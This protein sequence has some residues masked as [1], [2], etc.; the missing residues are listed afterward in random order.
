MFD[1][2]DFQKNTEL[3]GESTESNA[4]AKTKLSKAFL[5]ADLKSTRLAKSNMDL[6]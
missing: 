3:Y 2:L 4:P 1:L 6:S 5:L